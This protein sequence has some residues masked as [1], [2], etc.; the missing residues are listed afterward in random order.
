LFWQRPFF[1]V[2]KNDEI[3]FCFSQSNFYTR[4]QRSAMKS[5]PTTPRIKDIARLA[6]VSIG[7]VDRVLH[8][9]G[10]VASPTRDKILKIA[11][12]LSYSPNLMARALKSK[13]KFHIVVL[14]PEAS[15]PDSFWYQHQIGLQKA[16]VEL[17]SLPVT[18]TKVMFNMTSEAGFSEKTQEV[19]KLAPQGVLIAPIFKKETA[20]FCSALS[21]LKIPYLFIDS[22]IAEADFLAF[23]GEDAYQSGRVAAQLIDYGTPSGKDILI[24]NIARNFENTLH[25]SSRM[26]GFLSYFM[27]AG[28]N[29]G[30]KI[31]LEIQHSDYAEVEAKLDQVMAQNT[32]IGAV[33]VTSSKAYEIAQYFEEHSIKNVNL[34][35][36]D[37]V[38]R[39][40]KYL[41]T[42]Y[43]RFLLSQR[44]VEQVEIGLKKLYE[45]MSFNRVP[46][47]MEY[48]PIDVITPE[49]INFFI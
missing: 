15:E 26:Q 41:R 42:G 14:L 23:I 4:F 30:L 34:V 38:E 17:A 3:P 13:A 12:D 48:L 6:E 33:F 28:S 39:N 19:L 44:P 35:G 8:N 21:K 49:N 16:A 24:V 5:V 40:I 36:Y 22:Y 11:N 29:N 9:R 10:E 45:F 31:S 25:L 20:V 7:T 37:M 47:K 27:D 18:I 32:N 2:A 1:C 46:V 43:I